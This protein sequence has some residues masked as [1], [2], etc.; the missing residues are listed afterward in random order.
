[1]GVPSLVVQ[2]EQGK[3]KWPNRDGSHHHHHLVTFLEEAESFGWQD[4]SVQG[5]GAHDDTV[6][7]WWHL[8]WAMDYLDTPLHRPHRLNSRVGREI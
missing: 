7:S 6:L 5:L 3:W 4:G 1:M 8:A 2:V